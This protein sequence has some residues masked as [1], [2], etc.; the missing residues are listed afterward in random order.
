MSRRSSRHPSTVT[1]PRPTWPVFS[2]RC[3]NQRHTTLHGMRGAASRWDARSTRLREHLAT[4]AGRVDHAAMRETWEQLRATRPWTGAAVW[5]HGDMHPGNLLVQDGHLA[6]VLDF[7]D[8]TAGDPATDLAVA[9][10]LLH[11]SARSEFRELTCGAHGWL[12][13]DTWTRAR[14]WALA[15]GAAWLANAGANDR[16]ASVAAATIDE[17]ILA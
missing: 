12:D 11:G 14:A 7:G 4:I 10:M 6:G 2:A 1:P 9:W 16:L 15:L 3:I 8:L 13:D 17:A 5:I